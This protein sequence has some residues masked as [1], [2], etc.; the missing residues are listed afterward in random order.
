MGTDEQVLTQ[1]L[2]THVEQLAGEIGEHN[3][4]HLPSLQAAASYIEYEWE[5]QGYAV[6]DLPMTSREFVA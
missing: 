3:I 5:L 2:E 4:F 1:R 6:R